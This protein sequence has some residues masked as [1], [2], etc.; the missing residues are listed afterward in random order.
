MISL[1]P[2]RSILN[3]GMDI[4]TLSLVL[5]LFIYFFRDYKFS[6]LEWAI[7]SVFILLWFLIDHKR[8]L[9]YSNKEDEFSLIISNHIKAYLVFSVLV[10]LF[11]LLFPIPEPSK[12]RVIAFVIGFP[13]LGISLNLLLDGLRNRF[14]KVKNNIKYTLVAGTGNMAKNVGKQLNTHQVAGYKIK[15]FI[16]CLNKEECLV[17]QENVVSSLSDIRQYLKENRV[18]EI[19]IALPGNP[20][21]KIHNILEVADYFGIRVKYIPDYNHLFGTNCKISRFGGIDAVNIRQLPMDDRFNSFLK[22][23]FD[24]MFS[25]IVLILLLPLFL[26]LAILIKIDSPG[27]VLYCPMRIGRAGKPFKV[28]KFRSMRENDSSSE[29]VL[30]TKKNDP[31]VSKLGKI[32]RKYS[33]DELPQ[34]INVFL[35]EMSVVGPRPHRRFLDEQLQESVFR[36]MI[37]HYVKPGITGWAQVNG[38]RGPTDTEE[39]KRQRTL[40]D[41]WY[42]E[43]W[44]L[45]LDI[46]IIFLTLFSR[47]AHKSAF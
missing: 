13:V 47:K 8:R 33:L 29:G 25:G 21:K 22:R 45:W 37:R 18:D 7:L 41:L 28:Y 43:N 15:G 32:L 5:L 16:N 6:K 39:Q 27:P 14:K 20:R 4:L 11:Y 44:S 17:G 24:E 2:K 9:Y 35:G 36:Y 12:K 42:L 34:F 26:M 46:K 23:G 1:K 31:R 19:V 3:L 10:F 40:H 30:S 38:W